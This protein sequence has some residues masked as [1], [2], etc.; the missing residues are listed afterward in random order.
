MPP[1]RQRRGDEL[2]VEDLQKTLTDRVDALIESHKEREFVST[3]GTQATLNELT[4]RVTG[5]ELAVREIAAD[6]HSA[7]EKRR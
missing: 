4:A 2:Q 1:N 7:V 3:M 6:L 5:L